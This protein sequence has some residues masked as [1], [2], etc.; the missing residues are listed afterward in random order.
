MRFPDS[1][2]LFPRYLD[3]ISFCFQPFYDTGAVL[4]ALHSGD[5]VALSVIEAVALG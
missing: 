1:A 5:E 4:Y 2:D 3:L